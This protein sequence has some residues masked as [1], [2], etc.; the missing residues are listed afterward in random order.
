MSKQFRAF[1]LVELLVVIAIIGVLIALLLPAVQAAREAARRS[2]CINHLKQIGI[3]IH[4]MHDT[5]KGLPPACLGGFPRTGTSTTSSMDRATFFVLI[6]PYIELTSLTSM[7]QEINTTRGTASGDVNNC[8]I[9]IGSYFHKGYWDQLSDE[10]K[11]ALGSVNIYRCPTRS[12]GKGFAE[13]TLPSGFADA[14]QYVPGPF[15]DYAVVIN[16]RSGT[17]ASLNWRLFYAHTPIERIEYHDGPLRTALLQNLRSPNSWEV[18]DDMS[19]WADGS[20]NQ[21]VVGEK[22][23]PIPEIGLC[24]HESTTPS[25]GYARGHC[26][27]LVTGKE[28]VA[29]AFALAYD[30]GTGYA[31]GLAD[32]LPGYGYNNHFG[33]LHPGVCNFVMGDGS[34]HSLAVTTP[35]ATI[36]AL[37]NVND[38]KTV[39]F[40]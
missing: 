37:S 24:G 10:E 13:Q 8:Y 23:I 32:H 11:K 19:R 7:L 22:H 1:T 15:T 9:G 39:K 31:I 30:A 38:G 21:L 35:T 3:G 25:P 2:Q 5:L 27:Y 40:P 18:R 20:S 29:G 26:S 4:N 14:D 16:W 33:S 36:V 12:S 6:Y 34:V 28:R 17:S